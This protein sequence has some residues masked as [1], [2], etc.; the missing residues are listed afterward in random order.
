MHLSA[1]LVRDLH[2]YEYSILY[3][4]ERL[5][6]R[7]TW[8]PFDNLRRATRL[9]KS[10]LE[11]RLG[12]LVDKNLIRYDIVPYQGYSLLHTGLD[13]LALHTLSSRG[14]VSALG[15]LIGVGKE[16]VVYEALG[17]GVIVLKFHRIGQQ[18][19]QSVRV[20]REYMTNTG[21]CP[22]IFASG[23]S[24]EK[25]Y[26]ALRRLTGR[27]RVPVP[28]DRSRHTLAM[29]YIP[30]VN[31]NNCRLEDPE[32]VYQELIEEV[33]KAYRLGMIHADLSE[34]NVMVNED[35]CWIID[36]PQW[37][38]TTHPNADELIRH[39][40][41]TIVS[42]FNRKYRLSLPPEDALRYVTG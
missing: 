34:Y 2:K 13:T 23:L 36:W 9:S 31:L 32:T 20:N 37:T 22:W 25:E 16:S 1:D 19:F 11:F 41:E 8:V 28:I 3:A 5:M 27:V 17:L 42:F 29:S 15:S 33:R 14:S 10:E 4:I 30:G 12:S 35:Q 24:A 18:S 6:K 26:E 21:H 39:D 7:Y 40:V 38:E